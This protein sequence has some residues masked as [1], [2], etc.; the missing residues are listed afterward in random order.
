MALSCLPE[1]GSLS[2][3]GS[4]TSLG[5]LLKCT[6]RESALASKGKGAG[7]LHAQPTSRDSHAHGARVIVWAIVLSNLV[8]LRHTPVSQGLQTG[9][10]R[11]SGLSRWFR[12]KVVNSLLAMLRVGDIA[13]GL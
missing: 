9:S 7:N 12:T 11:G 1:S 8:G 4:Q 3:S 2:V 6:P 10:L 13:V 5:C